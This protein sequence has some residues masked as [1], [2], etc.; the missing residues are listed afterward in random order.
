LVQIKVII[1]HHDFGPDYKL[2]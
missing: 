2:H 1:T